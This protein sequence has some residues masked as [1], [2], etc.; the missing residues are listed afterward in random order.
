MKT[1]LRQLLLVLILTLTIK[2]CSNEV[3]VLNPESQIVMVYAY[4]ATE[5][6]TLKLINEHRV[7]IGKNPLILI[8]H[9]SYVAS[10]HNKHMIATG[11]IGHQ[12]FVN[13]ENTIMSTLGAKSVG[14]NIAYNYHT[15][16]DVMKAWISSPGHKANIEGNYTHFGISV[17]EHPLSGKKY[18]TNIFLRM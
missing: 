1:Y 17:T 5:T 12:D 8:N 11:V 16:T 2:S 18:Y 3:I 9:I 15:A 13:R 14:E 7:S 6:E 10:E 4:N